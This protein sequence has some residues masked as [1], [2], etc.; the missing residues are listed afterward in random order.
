MTENE[1]P[2]WQQ[3]LNGKAAAFISGIMFGVA[4]MLAFMAATGVF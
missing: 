1:M 3:K 4:I 2:L